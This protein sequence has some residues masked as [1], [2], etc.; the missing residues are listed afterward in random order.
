LFV[1]ENDQVKNEEREK[2][3]KKEKKEKEGKRRGDKFWFSAQVRVG[4]QCL[5][6]DFNRRVAVIVTLGFGIAVRRYQ[7]LA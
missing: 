2:N 5:T 4:L 1:H 7:L 3:K 6:I